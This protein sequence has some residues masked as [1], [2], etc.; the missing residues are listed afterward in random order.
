[1]ATAKRYKIDVLPSSSPE[2]AWTAYLLRWDGT[3]WMT[4]AGEDGDTRDEAIAE[5]QTQNRQA[6]SLEAT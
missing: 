3:G 1:M 6:R 5:L 2:W 4:E